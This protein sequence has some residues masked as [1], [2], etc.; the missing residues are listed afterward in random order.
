MQHKPWPPRATAPICWCMPHIESCSWTIACAGKHT[1]VCREGHTGMTGLHTPTTSPLLC[2]AHCMQGPLVHARAQLSTQC[3][4]VRH[5]LRAISIVQAKSGCAWVF[6]Q[7]PQAATFCPGVAKRHH[8]GRCSHA[9]P[10][11]PGCP[12]L[13]AQNRGVSHTSP[14]ATWQPSTRKHRSNTTHGDTSQLNHIAG[15]RPHLH[16][17]YNKLWQLPRCG[18][19]QSKRDRESAPDAQDRHDQNR[20]PSTVQFAAI[21]QQHPST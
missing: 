5:A 16:C 18:S 1:S 2:T 11:P 19:L 13:V 9:T 4:V 10:K 3:A 12:T 17:C 6:D 14:L 20:D 15:A 7:L 21:R 8:T